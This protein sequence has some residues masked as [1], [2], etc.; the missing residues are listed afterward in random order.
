MSSQ[1]QQQQ[2]QQWVP[3]AS[4]EQEKLA[5]KESDWNLA[6]STVAA[7]TRT[8]HGGEGRPNMNIRQDDDSCATSS[9]GT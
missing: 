1:Q 5:P 3:D 2:Q 7:T 4:L 6:G 9:D 8:R